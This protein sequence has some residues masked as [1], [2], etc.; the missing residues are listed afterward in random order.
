MT[1]RPDVAHYGPTIMKP[2]AGAIIRIS[3]H[4]D[5]KTN[6]RAGTRAR[7]LFTP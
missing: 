4:Y 2:V 1:P 6:I 7:N 5:A 3:V